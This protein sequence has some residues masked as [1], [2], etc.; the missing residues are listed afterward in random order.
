M[1]NHALEA[2]WRPRLVL[3]DLDNTLCD[4]RTSL[5][6]RL[7]H[8]FRQAFP[9]E[10]QRE[11]LIAA[12]VKIATDGT[13]H[14]ARLFEEE[15][16]T[17][18]EILDMALDRYQSDRFRGLELFE[19]TLDAI[20]AVSKKYQ[21]AIITNGPT[22][23]QQ[24]KIDLLEIEPLFSFILISEDTGFWKPDP[25]I[26]ELAL[27]HAGVPAHEAIYVGDSPDHDIAGAK[28]AGIPAVWMNRLEE[29]WPGGSRPDYEVR[30]LRT[31]L[32]WLDV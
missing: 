3:F 6:I 32:D 7:D 4:H 5:L 16:V 21:V 11:R 9:D 20:D 23:I 31:L 15:G 10:D 19:D 18:P 24:P 22:D 17:S 30:D 28:A 26:F 8:A 2:R 13:E 25:R 12:S 1:K 14:F 27:A 29:N